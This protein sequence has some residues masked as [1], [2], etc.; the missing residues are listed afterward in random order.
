LITFTGMGSVLSVL[1]FFFVEE[2]EE[3]EHEIIY[4]MV[5]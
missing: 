4:A 1:M 5:C 3:E 2:E